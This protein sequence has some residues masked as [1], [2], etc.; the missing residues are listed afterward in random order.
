MVEYFIKIGLN[1]FILQIF[2]YL[3]FI[4]KFSTGVAAWRRKL[5]PTHV[6]KYFI[7]SFSHN[8]VYILQSS[9]QFLALNLWLIK[10]DQFYVNRTNGFLIVSFIQLWILY[11][12][13]K[14]LDNDL[15]EYNELTQ[16]RKT[17]FVMYDVWAD[18]SQNFASQ[19]DGSSLQ[20]LTGIGNV[21]IN[22]DS[23]KLRFNDSIR[24]N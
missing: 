16:E 14:S 23:L 11:K 19:F 5:S 22:D 21:A 15:I 7:Y 4:V 20:R 9:M 8:G 13:V 10:E 18:A 6:N 12:F 1:L 3:S 24:I 2:I 17:S